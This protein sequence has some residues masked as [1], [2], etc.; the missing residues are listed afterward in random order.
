MLLPF[1]QV[2]LAAGA[3]R[4]RATLFVRSWSRLVQLSFTVDYLGQVLLLSGKGSV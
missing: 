3:G 1:V 4:N 2:A